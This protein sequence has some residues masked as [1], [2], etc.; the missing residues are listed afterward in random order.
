MRSENMSPRHM[1][2]SAEKYGCGEIIAVDV[3]SKLQDIQASYTVEQFFTGR[4]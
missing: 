3:V 4:K 2:R 1:L